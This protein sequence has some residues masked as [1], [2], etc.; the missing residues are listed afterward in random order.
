LVYLL[1]LACSTYDKKI[2]LPGKQKRS[3]YASAISGDEEHY[4]FNPKGEYEVF[5]VDLDVSEVMVNSTNT[6]CFGNLQQTPT[7]R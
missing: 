6:K 4:P 7:M 3:V 5:H 2:T 1:L